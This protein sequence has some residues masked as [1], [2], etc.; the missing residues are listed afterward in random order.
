MF[1]L[2]LSE[3]GFVGSESPYVRGGGSRVAVRWR[4]WLDELSMRLMMHS[5]DS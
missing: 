5:D 3:S 2:A 1:L 4:Q